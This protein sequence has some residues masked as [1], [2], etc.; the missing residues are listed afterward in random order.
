MWQQA[1]QNRGINETD[2]ISNHAALEDCF[3]LYIV[4][5]KNP[6]N[7]W[8]FGLAERA[9]SNIIHAIR[10]QML[11][12]LIM[13]SLKLI[14]PICRKRNGTDLHIKGFFRFLPKNS[15]KKLTFSGV[16]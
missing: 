9:K 4:R 16:L 3:T 2:L 13:I 5:V 7:I 6:W 11:H 1:E 10:I 12:K 15:S 8:T 14:K